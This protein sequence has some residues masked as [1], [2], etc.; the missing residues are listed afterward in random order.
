MTSKLLEF[1]PVKESSDI[2]AIRKIYLA[3][4]STDFLK[5]TTLNTQPLQIDPKE[6]FIEIPPEKQGIHPQITR[7]QQKIFQQSGFCDDILKPVWYYKDEKNQAF[8][9]INSK[10]MDYFLNKGV[11]NV[12]TRVAFQTLDK[13]VKVE[14]I[15]AI[16]QQK[17][18]PQKRLQTEEAPVL[19][20][21]Q[22][23]QP[24]KQEIKIKQPF[25]YT[26]LTIDFDLKLWFY[27]N[28]NDVKGPIST[29][30]I[31]KM[32]ENNQLTEDTKIGFQDQSKWVKLDQILSLA[33]KGYEEQYKAQPA[34]EK[35]KDEFVLDYSKVQYNVITGDWAKPNLVSRPIVAVVIN[36]DPKPAERKRADNKSTHVE[37]NQ[38]NLYTKKGYQKQNQE[39]IYEE[40]TKQKQKEVQDYL[41]KLDQKVEP[42]VQA[43]QPVQ[44]QKKQDQKEKGSAKKKNNKEKKDQQKAKQEQPVQQLTTQA[45]P[46]Q[47]PVQEE[48]EQKPKEEPVQEK[49]QV[50]DEDDGWIE[51]KKPKQKPN[52]Q[53]N[54]INKKVPGYL[55]QQEL[56]EQQERERALLQQHEQAQKSA[57]KPKQNQQV[58][59][60]DD[61][62]WIQAKPKTKK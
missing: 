23:T 39:V 28:G 40:D 4:F 59:N 56:I 3:Y 54:N 8:G 34:I 16:V 30:E 29:I 12:Q 52:Q 7:R 49:K 15:V 22:Q 60:D 35:K 53:K 43:A 51:V 5:P 31:D 24:I 36:N 44:E 45:P 37:G 41:Q 18:Q 11:I 46:Q 1:Q 21:V 17:A 42:A 50:D 10:Q 61:D 25:K 57:E 48:P 6:V 32:Y 26:G 62:G 47:V 14:K 38:G 33:H 58:Q 27:K 2:A 20:T 9:P 19:T 55:T 13:F